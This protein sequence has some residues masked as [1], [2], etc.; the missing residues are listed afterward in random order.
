MTVAV[1]MLVATPAYPQAVSVKTLS[2][3]D[4]AFHHG[5]T[6]V[7]G[8]RELSDGRVIVLDV[9]DRS[10]HVIDSPWERIRQIGRAGDG[11]REYRVPTNPLPLPGDSSVVLDQQNNRLLVIT[12]D[13]RPGGFL[14]PRGAAG[15]SGMNAVGIQLAPVSAADGR[16][17]FYALANPIVV[18]S[19]GELQVADSAAVERWTS[20]SGVRD[21]VG[22][23]PFPSL[24][25]R[26]VLF[27]TILASPVNKAFK[28][29]AQWAIGLDGRLAIVY[30]DPYRV[31]F[32]HP[33]GERLS[34]PPIPYD[35]L[36]VTNAHKEQW[37]EQQR[38]KRPIRITTPDGQSGVVSGSP[39]PL[40]P[41][42]PNYLPPF[43]GYAIY[44]A[45]NGTLW[46]RRTTPAGEPS[47]FDVIDGTGQVIHQVKLPNQRRLVG[48]GTGS[49]YLVQID[50]VDL[51]YL[52]RY[53]LPTTSS[54]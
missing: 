16:G 14:N 9:N 10:V 39:F 3:P 43:L 21:T 54:P 52:E 45:S 24:P 38:R 37:R 28:T 35:R 4:A 5:F 29:W 23:V 44:F 46:V 1:A 30:V 31:D 41:K 15:Q 27:G 48:F 42:W 51:E 7:Q 20:I 25:N 6:R 49:V 11:P 26:R 12:P 36:R 2:R 40:E 19:D 17:F 32:V 33:T 34:G 22:F 47:T 53:R 13:A 18:S 8:I 50:E